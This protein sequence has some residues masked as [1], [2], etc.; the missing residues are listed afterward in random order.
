MNILKI[1]VKNHNIKG[2]TLIELSIVMIIIG[3]IIGGILVGQELIHSAQNR[4]VITQINQYNSAVTAFQSKYNAFPGDSTLATTFLAN[5]SPVNGN[6]DGIIGNLPNVTIIYGNSSATQVFSSRSNGDEVGHEYSQFWAQLAGESFIEDS[7]TPVAYA[8]DNNM[9]YNF[10]YI[11]SNNN[12][13]IF[14]Y[15]SGKNLI[16]YYYLGAVNYSSVAVFTSINCFSPSDA[17][18]IDSKMDDGLPISGIVVARNGGGAE[19]SPSVTGSA[20][21]TAN[22]AGCVVGTAASNAKA[23]NNALPSSNM[24]CSLRIALNL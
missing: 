4:A 1:N 8:I 24:Q 22:L 19:I 21:L 23:Y 5:N 6:G 12:A 13:G 16:N 7:I 2:F 9:G 20:T 3:L 17:M 15:G 11:K 14:I 10:P 18:N